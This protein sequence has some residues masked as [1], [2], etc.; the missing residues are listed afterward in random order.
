VTTFEKTTNIAWTLI[1]WLQI[2]Q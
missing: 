2:I 1:I